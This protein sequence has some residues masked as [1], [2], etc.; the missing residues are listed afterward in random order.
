M[1]LVYHAHSKHDLLVLKL[2]RDFLATALLYT[3]TH[4]HDLSTDLNLPC[5]ATILT[6]I[7][8]LHT[9]SCLGIIS[10]ILHLLTHVKTF[11]V[12]MCGMQRW[13]I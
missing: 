8:G 11:L 2:P 4:T 12:W 7:G 3:N 13:A 1:S 6:C 9:L 5:V 10:K